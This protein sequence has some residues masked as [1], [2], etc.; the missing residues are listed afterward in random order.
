MGVSQGQQI[1][2]RGHESVKNKSIVCFSDD[3]TKD[4]NKKKTWHICPKKTKK[5]KNNEK[6]RGLLHKCQYYICTH[7]CINYYNKKTDW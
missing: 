6:E 1:R 3:M 4:V 2:N 7:A 5:K